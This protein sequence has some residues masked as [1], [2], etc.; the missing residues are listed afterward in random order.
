MLQRL[1]WRRHVF[2]IDIETCSKCGGTVKVITCIEE[3][4]VIEKMLAH[5]NEKNPPVQAPP[6][7]YSRAP[8]Q[9]T[10]FN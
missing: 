3:P 10:L 9:I 7:P 5:L 2:K 1:L 8:P 4:V 6:L